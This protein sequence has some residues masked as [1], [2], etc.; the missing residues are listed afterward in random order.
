M[1]IMCDLIRRVCAIYNRS[2][3]TLG[4]GA[5]FGAILFHPRRPLLLSSVSRMNFQVLG[6]L[7][8]GAG[9]RDQGLGIR[10]IDSGAFEV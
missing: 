2:P 7:D 1:M 3:L 10:N 5:L 6:V 8:S 9:F 4:A